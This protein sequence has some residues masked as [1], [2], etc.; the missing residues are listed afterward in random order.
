MPPKDLEEVDHLIHAHESEGQGNITTRVEEIC[1]DKPHLQ[2]AVRK[3]LGALKKMAWLSDGGNSEEANTKS[4]FLYQFASGDEPIPGVVLEKLIGQGG[5]GQVW[6]GKSESIPSLAIK[7]LPKDKGST[8][9]EKTTL[10]WLQAMD[11]PN[12]L[13]IFELKETDTFLF[14][15]MELADG[16]LFDSFNAIKNPEPQTS[17]FRLTPLHAPSCNRN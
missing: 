10:A 17:L 1:K 2:E 7:I 3:R 12:L 6:Q 11:H 4:Q 9:V 15:L 16:T 8:E 14:V 13:K 5:F